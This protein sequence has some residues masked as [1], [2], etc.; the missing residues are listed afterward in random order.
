[1]RFLFLTHG[2]YESD[3]YGRVSEELVRRGHEAVHVT[4][5]SLAAQALEA[6]GIRAF[7]LPD[8]LD[9]AGTGDLEAEAARLER[10]YEMRSLRDVWRTDWPLEGRPEPEALER[11][12]RHFRALE[13]IFDDV[14]PDVVVPEVG[15]ETFRTAAHLIGLERGIDVLFLFYTIFP[16]PLR[17]YRNTMHAPIVA[18]EDV[19]ELTPGEA[20]EVDRFIA[21][22]TAKA[23]PI[24]AYR[25]PRVT[26]EA[27]RDLAQHVRNALT[28]DRRNEYIRPERYVKGLVRERSRALAARRL[29]EPLEASS[30]PFVYF[31]LHVTDDYKIKRVIPHCVD[32]AA[33]I[34][35]IAASLPQGIDLVLKEHPMSIGRNPL[36]LLRRLTRHENIRLV[37]PYT[38]SHELIQRAEAIAVISSTVGLE[39]LLYDRPVLT[40]GQPF[41]SGYGVTVDVDSLRELPDAT[42]AL[43]RFQPDRERT[44][45]FIGAAMRA[46]YPGKPAAVDG[47]D[48]N[49]RVVAASLDA[50]TREPRYARVA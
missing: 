11:T 22:F 17:L 47:S 13:R 31:P 9:R 28:V 19:R 41:Y 21:E 50:A 39:A 3:F 8:A 37:E 49:A 10:T 14:Q 36:S 29:Y 25:A 24:R 38:S 35:L 48:E 20:A 34:E 16:N 4:W 42:A 45:R 18:Q 23:T 7:V 43:L 44:L 6:R 32:Q 46:C 15:S 1:M 5:S 30:R 33:I 27:G 26:L 12:V 40:V 2:S